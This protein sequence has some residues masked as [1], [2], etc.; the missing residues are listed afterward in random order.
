MACDVRTTNKIKM[1]GSTEQC[2]L[3]GQE[4]QSAVKQGVWP[5]IGVRSRSAKIDM[6]YSI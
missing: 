1:T 4:G 6:I 3:P 2:G 5:T